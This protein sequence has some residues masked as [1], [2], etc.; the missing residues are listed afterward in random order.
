[1]ALKT[2]VHAIDSFNTWTGKAAALL[3]YPM[4]LILFYEIFVRTIFNAP[5]IWAHEL[6]GYVFG[7]YF[8]L[9]GAYTLKENAHVK[10]DIFSSKFSK[11]TLAIVDII[12]SVLVILF[13]FVL[14]WF[15]TGLL[16][17]QLQ[18]KEVSQTVFAPPVFPL[19]LFIVIGSVMFLFQ[20]IAKLIRDILFVAKGKDI[21]PMPE[22]TA[23]DL[24]AA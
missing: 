4:L 8:M 14:T 2:F 17:T 3:I 7:A 10:V 21:D 11:R 12:T 18:R 6:D 23:Q 1:M 24:E 9:G 19:T 16:L 5:T 13:L 22:Q 15:A 20:A